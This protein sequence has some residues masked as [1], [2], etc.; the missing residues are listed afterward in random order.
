MVPIIICEYCLPTGLGHLVLC[1]D[2]VPSI[3]FSNSTRL[4]SIP[5][6]GI[7][8]VSTDWGEGVSWPS[9]VEAYG[10]ALLLASCNKGENQGLKL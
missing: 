3:C 8:I 4:P 6:S 7:L 9:I 1:N 10:G 2:A 5:S